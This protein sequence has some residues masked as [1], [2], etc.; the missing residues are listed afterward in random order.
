MNTS[1]MDVMGAVLMAAV[2]FPLSFFVARW[3]LRGV[4]KVLTAA[5]EQKTLR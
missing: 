5:D 3:C 1:G 2:T 4:V